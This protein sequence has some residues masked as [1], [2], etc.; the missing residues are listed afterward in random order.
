MKENFCKKRHSKCESLL[1]FPTFQFS[2]YGGK[3][4]PLSPLA[5]LLSPKSQNV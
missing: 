2:R 4:D 1:F 5:T 3:H